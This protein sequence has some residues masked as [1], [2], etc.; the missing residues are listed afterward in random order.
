[1]ISLTLLARIWNS[2]KR[3]HFSALL[4][5]LVVFLAWS[6]LSLLSTSL[7]NYTLKIVAH[8]LDSSV[9][10]M[11]G[12][13]L[14]TV[15]GIFFS[16]SII[17]VQHAASNYT[18]SILEQYKK[19]GKTLFVLFYYWA[20]LIMAIFSLQYP[21]NLYL[22]NVMI[23][24]FI[25]SFLFLASQFVHIIDL[26]DPREIIEKTKRAT[27]NN[28]K[29]I[30][31]RLESVVKKAKP[32]ND[33]ERNFMKLPHYKYAVLHHENSL[34]ASTQ[35]GVL[36]ISDVVMKAS[37]RRE[38][39]TCITGLK[40]L[41]QIVEGYVSI[42]KD[43]PTPDDA[44]IQ[45]VSTQ[46]SAIFE[47]ALENRDTLLLQE[48][49]LA[50]EAVGCSTTDIKP[51]ISIYDGPNHSTN[52]TV[53]NISSLGIKAIE[54]GFS[55]AAVQAIVSLKKIG[56]LAIQKTGGDGLASDKIMDIGK[57]GV[58]QGNWFVTNHAFDGLKEVL[59]SAIM[60][61]V[62]VYG[63]PY[64]ILEN[65]ESLAQEGI[66]RGLEQFAFTSLFPMLPENSIEKIAWAAFHIK[67][68]EYPE[69]ETNFREKY[70]KEVMSKF[71][72]T[73]GRIAACASEKGHLIL[74]G[75]CADCML[76]IAMSMLKEKLKTIEEG[77][78]SE[79][80]DLINALDECY[81]LSSRYR[82]ISGI[83][84]PISGNVADAVTSIG[85][86]ALE[87]EQEDI[88][89]HCLKAL[90]H[91]CTSMIEQDTFGY[92][93]ARCAARM[94]VIGVC[95]LYKNKLSIVSIAAN[96]L[97]AFDKEYLSKSPQP[98]EGRHMKEVH[99]LHERAILEHSEL[100][101]VE[102]YGILFK[103]VPL[104]FLNEFEKL[105]EKKRKSHVKK[106]DAK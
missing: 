62:N 79:I 23:W 31:F 47:V 37:K 2:L 39:E 46:F 94:G 32:K 67:N 20:S 33:F 80:I 24:L 4:V 28:I 5:L 91:M 105:F 43:D 106:S 9:F 84:A 41:S 29:H 100:E 90:H 13:I 12:T 92:D 64:A 11:M 102:S 74:A 88:T 38:L 44:F 1:V 98:Q 40:A 19:D 69:I 81:V 25:F 61:Q 66:K 56:L 60:R 97:A 71:A 55:D 14:A 51:P 75:Q 59:F 16:I 89:E 42:R 63:E 83:H 70:S 27:L 78:K 10:S 77:Y 82:Y 53:W 22:I 45:Y 3:H 57:K 8:P 50:F 54:N 30:P 103:D 96:L 73:I 86:S 95:A 48:A 87:V 17:V 34:M 7:E 18:P 68:A 93:V 99:S 21:E 36:Q 15:L 104:S 6:L 58:V 65:I 101:E 76:R 52:V 85:I 72:E 49:V 35:M 26:I